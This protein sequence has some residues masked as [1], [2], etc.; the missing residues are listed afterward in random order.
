MS[1]CS[2]RSEVAGIIRA[3]SHWLNILHRC[4]LNEAEVEMKCNGFE[5]IKVAAR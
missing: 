1:H 3:L 2:H 5:A 4:N